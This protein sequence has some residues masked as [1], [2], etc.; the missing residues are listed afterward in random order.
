MNI[1]S[2]NQLTQLIKKQTL[3]LASYKF[4]LPFFCPKTKKKTGLAS[5]IKTNKGKADLLLLA[6][7]HTELNLEEL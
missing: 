1:T 6:L 3:K 4:Q 5:Q 7:H 2:R